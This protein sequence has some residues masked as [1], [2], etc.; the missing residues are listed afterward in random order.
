MQKRQKKLTNKNL[1][2]L[3]T[4]VAALS[5]VLTSGMIV[6][7][8]FAHAHTSLNVTS[9]DV[10]GKKISV[11]LGHTNEPTYGALPGIHDG[12]HAV[13]VLLSD[14]ATKLPLTGANLT[15]D[16]YYFNDIKS[17]SKA[18]SPANAD[19]VQKDVNVTSVFGDPGHYMARQVQKPGI[20]GYR[21][22]GTIS[23]FGI[24]SVPIDTTVFCK[25]DSGNTSKF[26]SPGWSGGFG[27]VN[28]IKDSAFP[29][30]DS[31]L[32]SNGNVN[33]SFELGANE[34]PQIQQSGFEG[35]NNSI[36]GTTTTMTLT[37]SASPSATSIQQPVASGA[38]S[39]MNVMQL[40][41]AAGIPATGIA[42]FIGIRAF[43]QKKQDI[44][45]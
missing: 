16:K 10:S 39:G 23:Y 26:N 43:R 4:V 44:P 8:A 28:D 27:C 19:E 31:A 22:Y 11:V 17:F 32:I 42:S 41:M 36:A 20:Y 1:V 24:A 37:S 33:A 5:F 18:K 3:A 34:D 29:Q 25:A 15:V 35:E 38:P 40:M 9:P 45:L 30:K 7:P 14:D 12:K 13:E 6:Q 2:M 21:L